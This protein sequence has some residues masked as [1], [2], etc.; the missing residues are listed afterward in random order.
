MSFLLRCNGITYQPIYTDSI[1]Y[2]TES[3]LPIRTSNPLPNFSNHS[4]GTSDSTLSSPF[5]NSGSFSLPS[6]QISVLVVFNYSFRLEEI[7]TAGVVSSWIRQL[8]TI[9]S[10]WSFYNIIFWYT[11]L[12]DV[13]WSY[14]SW[15]LLGFRTRKGKLSNGVGCSSQQ[16]TARDDKADCDQKTLWNRAGRGSKNDSGSSS[17]CL[18]EL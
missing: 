16:T 5:H 15:L 8:I 3:P 7:I 4:V 1:T 17:D 6:L 10:S 12:V 18:C 13:P 14:C 11:K 9:R 2:P